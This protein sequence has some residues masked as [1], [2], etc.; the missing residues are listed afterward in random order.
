MDREACEAE[1]YQLQIARLKFQY[2][3][4]ERFSTTAVGRED[5]AGKHQPSPAS[6]CGC[7][8]RKSNTSKRHRCFHSLPYASSSHVCGGGSTPARRCSTRS[9]TASRYGTRSTRARA[10]GE[11]GP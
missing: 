7:I 5:F 1:K 8:A 4:Y 10:L 6:Q 9:A 11:L 2:R 3:D